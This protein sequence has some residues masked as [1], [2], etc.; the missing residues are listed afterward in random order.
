MI[1]CYN[2]AKTLPITLSTIKRDYKGIDETEI[3][4]IND[5]SSDETSRVAIENG[6]DY[7]VLHNVTLCLYDVYSRIVSHLL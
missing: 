2:E 4:I 1:P 5:G 6:V 7:V 3:L